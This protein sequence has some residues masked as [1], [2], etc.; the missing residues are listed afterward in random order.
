MCNR[1]LPSAGLFSCPPLLARLVANDGI[2]LDKRRMP[3]RKAGADDHHPDNQPIVHTRSGAPQPR[4]ANVAMQAS[5]K[6]A[7]PGPPHQIWDLRRANHQDYW[8]VRWMARR[9]FAL[10]SAQGRVMGHITD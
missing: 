4:S 10:A 6:G 2:V 3:Q 7:K 8:Y 9:V 5:R 1:A